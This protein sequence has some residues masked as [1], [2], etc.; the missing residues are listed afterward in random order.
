M[1]HPIRCVRCGKILR[2]RELYY[3]RNAKKNRE[4]RHGYKS[5]LVCGTCDND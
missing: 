2:G 5:A 3:A 4:N 1:N